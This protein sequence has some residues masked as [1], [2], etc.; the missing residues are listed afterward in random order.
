MN[1]TRRT[2][3][4]YLGAATVA[5]LSPRL[6]IAATDAQGPAVHEIQMLSKDPDDKKRR[7]L[8]I[9]DL[10]C[11]K[12]GDTVRFIA[13]DKGHNSVSNKDMMPEGAESWK[14]KISKDI[15]V[16]LTVEGTYGFH[17][18]PHRSLGM[19]GLIIVGDHS[20]NYE[21]AKAAKQRGKA[22]SAYID[23]FERADA[24]LGLPKEG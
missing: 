17:C 21:A 22:K 12:P 9:P 23:L 1:H 15:E 13:T 24:L 4:K 8:F 20:G 10:I 7:N 14:G 18:A 5:S 6:A 11:I 2:H 19:V 3:L 16:T